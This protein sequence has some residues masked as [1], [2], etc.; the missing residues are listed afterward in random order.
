MTEIRHRISLFMESLRGGGAERVMLNLA[1]EFSRR[2]YQV[3]LVVA[4]ATGPYR[5][6]V[7][8]L[9]RLVDLGTTR[10]IT[11]MLP[12]AGYLRRE[13]PDVVLSQMGHCNIAS[14][15]ARKL[16]RSATRV[17]ISEVSLMGVSTA[18]P[19]QLRSRLIPLFA[20]KLYPQAGAI[21]AVSRGV[22]NDLAHVLDLPLDRI[23]V[24][25]NPVVTPELHERAGRMVDHPWFAAGAP[26]VII[27]VG[28]LDPEKDFLTF[29]RAFNIVRRNRNVRL[30]ILGEGPERFALESLA[31]E[32]GIAE[33]VT[34]AGFV[35]NP[36]PFI[37]N[38]SVLVLTSRF[39]GLSNV[40][41]E[42][43]ACGTPVVSTDCPSGPTEILD[44]GHYGKLAPV[45][46]AEALAT[47][48]EETIDNPPD[49]MF[50]KSAAE[51]FSVDL[52][53]RQYLEVLIG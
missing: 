47:A 7:P 18:N 41:I 1:R 25:Y 19:V 39:E 29:L 26:P 46:D 15:L 53:A 8:D 17:V 36:L 40:L 16:A 14:L 6:Q 52:I 9:V 37:A 35:E 10:T 51:R 13:S 33:I 2:N 49:R 5:S 20:K 21:I 23:D 32:L 11:A 28:R 50:L 24:I 31:Q 34:L 30:M 38:A 27:G 44:G 42:A 48:I 45:G 22:A 12:L 43:L 3:D 4:S